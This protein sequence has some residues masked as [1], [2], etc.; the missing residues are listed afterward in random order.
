MIKNPNI[1]TMVVH[2]KNNM[3][4]NVIGRKLGAK[5]KIAKVPYVVVNDKTINQQNKI[6]ALEHAEFISWCFNNSAKILV[7]EKDYDEMKA[8]SDGTHRQF[9]FDKGKDK[10]M[11]RCGL[12]AVKF[13]DSYLCS[14]ITVN[15]G[16]KF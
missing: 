15:S 14:G 10:V 9:V 3:A 11:C 16:C 1:K 4:W 8:I 7:H 13:Q 2:S 6:E 5:Y 12:P